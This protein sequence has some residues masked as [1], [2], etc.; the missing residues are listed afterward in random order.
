MAMCP[1]SGDFSTVNG[2]TKG[3]GKDDEMGAACAISAQ[4]AKHQ[5]SSQQAQRFIMDN[6]FMRNF[7]VL[8]VEDDADLR[9][10]V[11]DYLAAE[12][13]S[14]L[15]AGTLKETLGVLQSQHIQAVVL[16]VGLPDGNG[17]D[18]LPELRR[19]T[20][21]PIVMMTA[22]GQ[23]PL[24][25][26]G[27]QQGADY[28]LVKPVPLAELS[29]VLATLFRRS[30]TTLG[31]RTDATTRT[32]IAANEHSVRLTTSEWVFVQTLRKNSGRVVS[33][34]DLV[35]SL[36]QDPANYDPR[37]MD[38]LVQRL[39]RKADSAGLGVL[40]LQTRHGLGYVWEERSN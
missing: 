15:E 25:L 4:A 39:R 38:T 7:N 35:R 37:R 40:P 18:A 29:A 27:L 1:A 30:T 32:L 17:L 33:R 34:E 12:G 20:D 22:W 13:Y 26:K 21:C 14:V 16:D 24:R 23:L 10:E 5:P 28:Y 9:Q 2:N 19:H 3:G 31:W 36:S 6:R 8:L 11:R